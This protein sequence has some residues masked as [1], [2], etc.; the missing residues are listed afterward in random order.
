MVPSVL[1]VYDAVFARGQQANLEAFR[2]GVAGN[3]PGIVA[4]FAGLTATAQ[5]AVAHP[6]EAQLLFWRPVPDYRPSAQAMAPAEE[7]VN[8]LREVVRD[9]G[10]SRSARHGRGH[11]RWPSCAGQSALRCHQPA[12]G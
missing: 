5:W 6:V 4:L 9:R 10:R 1:G 12:L 11:R 7:L 8:E 2:A 3:E